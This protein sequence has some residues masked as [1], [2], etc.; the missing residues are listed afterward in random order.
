MSSDDSLV[1]TCTQVTNT[2]VTT[3]L[4]VTNVEFI[5]T[6]MLSQIFMCSNDEKIVVTNANTISDHIIVTNIFFTFMT[7][8]CRHKNKH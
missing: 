1:A 7:N 3:F 2:L 4:N 8:I 5:V 6:I